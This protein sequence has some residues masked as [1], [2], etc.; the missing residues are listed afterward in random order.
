M[1]EQYTY[2]TQKPDNLIAAWSSSGQYCPVCFTVS[3]DLGVFSRQDAPDPKESNWYIRWEV[4]LHELAGSADD[5][6]QFCCFMITRFFNDPMYTFFYGNGATNPLGC[7]YLDDGHQKT[8]KVVDAIKRTLEMC[9]K[10]GN[11]TFTLIAQPDD[12]SQSGDHYE[13]LRFLVDSTSLDTAKAVED[14]LGYRRQIVLEVS[15]LESESHHRFTP[16]LLTRSFQ[17]TLQDEL[18]R[19]G[20]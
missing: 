16:H 10:H 14:I 5:G 2:L 20:L 4:N 17:T 15:T 6:C 9:E 18:S 11:P 19:L 7:C 1:P 13:R 12:Y 8:N 3:R